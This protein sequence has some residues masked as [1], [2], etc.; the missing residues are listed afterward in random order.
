MY[1]NVL[2]HTTTHTFFLLFKT[3]KTMKNL[4]IKAMI[5]Q[6]SNMKL[7]DQF[8]TFDAWK[9]L[10][11]KVKK[12]EKTLFRLPQWRPFEVET[13]TK[14]KEWKEE[15]EKKVL[16]KIQLVNVF[17]S[18]QLEWF[19]DAMSE[20]E[21]MKIKDAVNTYLASIGLINEKDIEKWKENMKN[22]EKK[23]K[24][25]EKKEKGIEKVEVVEPVA[26]ENMQAIEMIPEKVLDEMRAEELYEMEIKIKEK[27][28]ELET[29]ENYENS[30]TGVEP[31]DFW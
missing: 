2:P 30:K 9:R 20:E 19:E 7:L 22:F 17:A 4:E 25:D 6:S 15:K 3:I 28:E 13:T 1:S 26:I 21:A 27:E 23:M 18:Y 16:F 10:W 14:N 31:F 12:G 11:F 29:V 5:L 24:E 8:Q